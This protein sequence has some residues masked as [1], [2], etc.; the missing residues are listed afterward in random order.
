MCI[1]STFFEHCKK[2]HLQL[3]LLISWIMSDASMYFW[4]FIRYVAITAE[5]MKNILT[6][7]NKQPPVLSG[8]DLLKEVNMYLRVIFS[9][10]LSIMF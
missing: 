10:Y 6:A 2:I 9:D 5:E 1:H 7:I 4:C 8:L 3:L